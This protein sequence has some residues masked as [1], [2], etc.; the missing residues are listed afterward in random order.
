[1]ETVNL[2][3]TFTTP[4]KGEGALGGLKALV[5]PDKKE[6]VAVKDVSLSVEP[7]E[8]VGFLGPNGAGKTTTLKM[9]SGIIHPTS[10]KIEVLGHVPTRRE[11]ELLRRLG[12]VMGNKNQL[13]WDLPARDSFEVLRRIYDVT[14]ADYKSRLDRLLPALELEDKI[15]QQVRKLSLG[16]R[17]K[18]ELVAALI[19]APSV[20]FLDEPTIGL[21]VV[22]QG[23]IREF[24]RE[25]HRER[26]TT[27]L[28]T[29]HYMQDVEALC[30]RIVIIDHGTVVFEG[31]LGDL[32]ARYGDTKTIR[33]TFS[34][35]VARNVDAR[36]ELARLAHAADRLQVGARDGGRERRADRLR[37]AVPRAQVA[38]RP[39]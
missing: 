21:D 17:M 36:G 9:L 27:M 39:L 8:V 29:S 37:V 11:P 3:K 7:G 32:R 1:M 33:A 14:D 6:V 10:G 38:Q 31:T 20:L 22:S 23:R 34:A 30:D 15:D 12:L 18:C 19:H 16:E 28:L 5:R 4:V 24:L 13:W 26:G 35:P 25:I 2:R